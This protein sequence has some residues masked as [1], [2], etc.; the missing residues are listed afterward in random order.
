MINKVIQVSTP[1]FV[2]ASQFAGLIVAS[3]QGFQFLKKYWWLC[4]AFLATL[5]CAYKYYQQKKAKKQ[6]K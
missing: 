3:I 6:T 1:V 2:Q 4:A 5:F